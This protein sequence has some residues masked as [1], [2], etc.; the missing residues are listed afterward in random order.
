MTNNDVTYDY[1]IIN[2][3]MTGPAKAL[4]SKY[5][6]LRHID[7]DKIIFLENNSSRD[8]KNKLAKISKISQKWKEILWQKGAPA[9]RYIIEFYCKTYRELSDEQKTALLYRELRRIS[10]EGDI[11]EPDI[12]DWYDL[13]KKL[14]PKW[15]ELYSS[16]PDLLEEDLHK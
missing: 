10:T 7:P 12:S 8:R 9:Y 6:E 2:N 5:D 13:I 11:L 16:C 3:L 4:V 15:S 1:K 14:G